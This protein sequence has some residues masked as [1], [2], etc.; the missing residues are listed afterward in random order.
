MTVIAWDGKTLAADRQADRGGVKQP[1]QKIFR[2]GRA[3][4]GISGDLTLCR[5]LLAWYS[6]GAVPA[7]FPASC[8]NFDASM[9]VIERGP[10][11]QAQAKIY[12]SG[13]SPFTIEAPHA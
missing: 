10:D 8:R 13:P 3:L 11:G 1:T 4:A 9:L 2:A 5:E 6:A 7:N 12:E